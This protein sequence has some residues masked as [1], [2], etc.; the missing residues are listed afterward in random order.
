MQHRPFTDTLQWEG[1]MMYRSK[2]AEDM[3]NMLRTLHNSGLKVTYI[4]SFLNSF[5]T[6][7]SEKYCDDD[8]LSMEIAEGW[9]HDTDSTSQVHMSRRVQTMKH[10]GK[11]QRMIGKAAYVA[12]YSIPYPKSA[13]PRLFTEE[14]LKE[15]FEKVDTTI[16]PTKAVPYRGIIFPVLLRL[17]YCCGLRSAE[18]CELKCEDVD[19]TNGILFI[20]DSK[21]NKDRAVYMS[22][23][24]LELCH[25][26][27]K[28]YSEFFPDRE[29]FFQPNL[30]KKYFTSGD[31]HNLFDA[32]ML[33]TSFYDP[34]A[35]K[36]TPHGLRH[37][38]AVENIR[39][40]FEAGGDFS[41][42]I[43]YLSR[44]MG[45]DRIQHTLY[46]LHLTQRLF[47]VYRDKLRS[48][49]ENVE[50]AYVEE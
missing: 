43:E 25:R 3:E 1:L 7:C 5:D 31:V 46:Y 44:Y 50:V 21:G 6:Y 38:F 34:N 35:K 30:K 10:L 27:H 40:C 41:N 15:F 28:K 4:N 14:Q 24:I 17:M 19:L 47:P 36:F 2:F 18:A 22:D 13:E 23:D 49:T 29:Y 26:F 33:K 39:R 9:I 20:M 12:N 32:V 42:R 45:H 48:L 37:L 16:M 8:I 11:Y